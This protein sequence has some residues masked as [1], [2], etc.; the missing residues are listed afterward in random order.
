MK[1]LA[2]DGRSVL[3]KQHANNPSD[4]EENQT[5]PKSRMEFLEKNSI[6]AR[7]N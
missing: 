4:A 2:Q 1:P 7:V 6:E 5:R 3:P